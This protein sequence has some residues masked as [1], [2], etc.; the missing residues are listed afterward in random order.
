MLNNAQEGVIS[1]WVQSFGDQAKP[2]H[3]TDLGVIVKDITGITP[4]SRWHQRFIRRHSELRKGKAHGL[5][6]KRAQNLNFTAVSEYFALRKQ[7]CNPFYLLISVL[8]DPRL[9]MSMEEFLVI[10]SGTWMS[11]VFS[12]EVGVKEII[13]LGFGL[14]PARIDIEFKVTVLI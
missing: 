10:T 7:V 9:K 5:D 8:I 13:G 4:S 1:S 2:L 14:S 12:V 11:Q 6:P 3:S